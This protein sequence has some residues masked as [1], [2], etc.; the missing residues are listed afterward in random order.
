[1]KGR[2]CNNCNQTG[3]RGRSAIFEIIRNSDATAGA[4]F[5]KAPASK[6][7]EIGISEGMHTLRSRALERLKEGL[8]TVEEVV[9]VTHF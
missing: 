4:I 9:R 6:I 7:R 1:V 3:Y 5:A 8:T 2:G